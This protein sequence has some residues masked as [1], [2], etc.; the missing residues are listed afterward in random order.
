MTT[1]KSRLTPAPTCLSVSHICAMTKGKTGRAG[2]CFN[3]QS[4][5]L[6]LGSPS[7]P[8]LPWSLES[9]WAVTMDRPWKSHCVHGIILWWWSQSPGEQSP[10]T[11]PGNHHIVFMVLW[12]KPQS[13]HGIWYYDGSHKVYMVTGIMMKTTKCTWY[14][15]DNHKVYT[16]LWWQPQ[17]VHGIVMTVTKCTW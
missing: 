9:G 10:W 5:L 12:W 17:S 16:V 1:Q 3:S 8:S 11:R 6:L 15:D 7:K 2:R 14:C 13:V 4:W